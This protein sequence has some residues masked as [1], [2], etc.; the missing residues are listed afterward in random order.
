MTMLPAW[1]CGRRESARLTRAGKTVAAMIRIYCGGLHD[2]RSALCEECA[3]LYAYAIDRLDRCPLKSEK[4]TC[5]QCLIHC[6]KADRRE[7]IR[8][9]MR[10]AGPR[11]LWRHPLLAVGQLL[12]GRRPVPSP[13]VKRP[14]A[15]TTPTGTGP[16]CP[17]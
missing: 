10:Y 2:R 17:G 16:G 5:A 13:P 8:A 6:Y 7:Q 11:M 14:A 4:P 3:A 15:D 12:D 9:V 1:L